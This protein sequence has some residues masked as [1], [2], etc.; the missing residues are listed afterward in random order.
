M[1]IA[2]E[3][4]IKNNNVK[5]N[6]NKHFAVLKCTSSGTEFGVKET[7]FIGFYSTEKD[8]ILLEESYE[9]PVQYELIGFTDKG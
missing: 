9:V 7:K 1:K 6:C 3:S 4:F 5:I 8:K 2:K